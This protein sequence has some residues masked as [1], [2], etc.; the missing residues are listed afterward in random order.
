MKYQI[1]RLEARDNPENGE[2]P[3]V[4]ATDVEIFEGDAGGAAG[5]VTELHL[6]TSYEHVAKPTGRGA[7]GEAA[8]SAATPVVATPLETPEE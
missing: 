1:T 8:S 5:R 6:E 7:S 3:L 2:E 4:T